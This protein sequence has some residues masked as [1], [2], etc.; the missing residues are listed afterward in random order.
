MRTKRLQPGQ[1]VFVPDFLD[2]LQQ[3]DDPASAHEAQWTGDWK[4]V[5]LAD[6]QHLVLRSWEEAGTARP[7]AIFRERQVALL[8]AAVLPVDARPT[9]FLVRPVSAEAGY[10]VLVRDTYGAEASE[11]D[12]VGE[13]FDLGDNQALALH[14]AGSFARS[15]Y[16]LALVLEA[17]GP[18]AIRLVGELLHRQMRDAP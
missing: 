9:L 12:P 3:T 10:A 13:V 4:V 5:S 2:R 14:L 17:A 16:A 7:A 18:T 8:C 15:P 1:T 6:D 11:S